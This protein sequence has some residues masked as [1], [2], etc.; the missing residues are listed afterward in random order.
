MK[1]DIAI[2]K[3]GGKKALAGLLLT[4]EIMH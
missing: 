3:I 1:G 4:K 2:E